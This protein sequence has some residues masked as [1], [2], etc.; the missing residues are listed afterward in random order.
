MRERLGP[1]R[2]GQLHEEAGF[3]Q[4]GNLR[5]SILEHRR[6][7]RDDEHVPF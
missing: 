4:F 1:P 5:M 7:L 6:V 3:L 2:H